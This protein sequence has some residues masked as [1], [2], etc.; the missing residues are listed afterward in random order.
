M[1]NFWMLL[2]QKAFTLT[3]PCQRRRPSLIWLGSRYVCYSMSSYLIILIY[4]WRVWYGVN[5]ARLRP[6][7]GCLHTTLHATDRHKSRWSSTKTYCCIHEMKPSS[8]GLIHRRKYQSASNICSICLLNTWRT[9]DLPSKSRWI[10][11]SLREY[12]HWKLSNACLEECDLIFNHKIWYSSDL[13]TDT[14]SA[15]FPEVFAWKAV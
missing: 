5:A 11:P 8:T 15:D 10:L 2:F 9:N 1:S 12:T 4:V 6:T 14:M 3:C 13:K 7:L